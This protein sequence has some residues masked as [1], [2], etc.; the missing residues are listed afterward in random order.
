MGLTELEI[1]AD[2]VIARI[3]EHAAKHADIC[4]NCPII[5]T[6]REYFFMKRHLQKTFNVK[7]YSKLMSFY[8]VTILRLDKIN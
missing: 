5:L 3:I 2:A 7:S 6:R 8:G 1:I 4:M